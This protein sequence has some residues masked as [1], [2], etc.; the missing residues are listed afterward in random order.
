M[1]GYIII[2]KSEMKFRE[3]DVYHSYYCGLCRTLKDRYGLSGQMTLSYDMTFLVML[4]TGLY[5]PETKTSMH[6]CIAHPLEKHLARTNAFT[7]YVADMNVLLSY[8]KCMDDWTDERKVWKLAY[9]KLLEGKCK[10]L[11]YA[12]SEKIKRVDELLKEIVKGEQEQE[13]N[14]DQMAGRFGSVMAEIFAWKQ[15]EWEESLRRIG[16]Y[17]GKFIYLMDAYEDL[18]QDK[19]K[20]TYNPFLQ[21]SEVPDFDE[22][23]RNILTMMMA[24]CSREFEKLPILEDVEILRNILYSGVWCRYE[25]VQKRREEKRIES[26]G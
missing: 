9:G 25:A 3:F 6:K 24:E 8:Y 11:E 23:S 17:L 4:L 16:F 1:F 10:K 18:E 14:I 19:K 5:E 26:H 13:E 20:G 12:Y 22:T 15:D 2:N 7:E 21:M